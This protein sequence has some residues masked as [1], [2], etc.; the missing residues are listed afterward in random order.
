MKNRTIVAFNHLKDV[1]F[2]ALMVVTVSG[3][4]MGG[5]V[6]SIRGRVIDKITKQPIIGAN[7]LVVGSALGS[8]TDVNGNF[9]IS[10]V[11][12]GIYKLRATFVGHTP[13]LKTDVRVVRDKT[14][15]VEIE[16]SE[17]YIE[18]EEVSVSANPFAINKEAP[19][20]NY[21]YSKE[22]INRSPGAAGDIFRAIETLPGVSSSGGEFSSFSVRGGSPKD[23]IVL[24]DNIP[25][26]RVSHFTGGS[27][28]QE[29][30]GGRFSIFAPNLIQEANF[31]A[32]GFGARYGGKNAS[33]VD[34]KIKDGNRDNFTMNGTFDVLGWEFNYDGPSYILPTTSLILSAR[35]QDFRTVLK[36][37]GQT[38]LGD[39]DFT[40][41]ILKTT[42]AIDAKNSLS[43]LG[44]YSPEKFERNINHVYESKELFQTELYD[45]DETKSVA[46]INWRLLAS[47]A[48]L[49][50]TTLYY[51]GRE[52]KQRYGRA[53]T[54]S[55]NGVIPS[56]EQAAQRKWIYDESTTERDFGAK[57]SFTSIIRKNVTTTSGVEVSN[58]K[59]DFTAVQNG[60]DTI[61]TF[62]ANDYRPDAAQK[63]LLRQA[64]AVN[65]TVNVSKLSVAAYT[66][67]SITVSDV[68]VIN[69]GVRFERSEF[70][71]RNYVSPRLSASYAF[72]PTTRLNV[73]GGI[74]YQTP[75]LGII[76]ADPKN[77]LSLKNERAIHAI[78]GLTD[79]F[80]D[81]VRFTV[82]AYYK[83][84]D[85]LVVWLDRTR[86]LA[87]NAGDGW[88]T[89]ADFSLVKRFTDKWYG[90]VNYS[91]AQSK[92]DDHDNKGEY[93]SDFN[94]PHIFN[95]LFGY[96]VN[97]EWSF[98]AKWKYATG[99]PTD[100]YIVHA[101]V[102]NN[103]NY[104]RYSKEITA[105]NGRRLD[106][107]HTFNLRVDYRKQLGR[108]ALVS[109]IDV[110]NVYNR[111]NV[112]EERFLERSGG[113]SKEGFEIIPTIG[114]KL[115]Y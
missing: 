83:K 51:K 3:I 28:E 37:T 94:Q 33:F 66:D 92:R 19:V 63:F 111:L 6:G 106:D 1:C 2:A 50:Q 70:N 75:E 39:P 52:A 93:N 22:E 60:V 45:V 82:E 67:V 15:N 17:D 12:E 80:S 113:V 86:L 109:F 97:E 31:Q 90:Q 5:E 34:L 65:S 4:A 110:L 112:N 68:L 57:V 10:P 105:N 102:H 77:N 46:G 74:F 32:G 99:R 100:A 14:T 115:E 29:A 47:E 59:L 8:S 26:D 23:N 73:A 114:I 16:L 87:V 42:T 36:L 95:I 53:F 35:H 43:I 76:T 78:L 11:N 48:S 62:D 55:F 7:V 103:P 44:I 96:E 71:N 9:T 40:D 101:N 24:V 72:S 85:D 69:P 20:S 18:S 27:E 54:D 61:Y 30:Q 41:I 98:A 91:Y 38:D 58:L 13:F 107:F 84:F 79:Y 88:A 56:K 104:L 49:L 25:V 89:G 64:E 108:F 81:D 21:T